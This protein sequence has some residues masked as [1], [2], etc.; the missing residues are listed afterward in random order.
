MA[1]KVYGDANNEHIGVADE[2]D[3]SITSEKRL[4]QLFDSG[5]KFEACAAQA[6]VIEGLA[7]HYLIIVKAFAGATVSP[8]VEAGLKN[9]RLTFG[10]VKDAIL[11]ANALTDA[12]LATDLDQYA[13]ERNLIAHHLVASLHDFDLD[14]FYLRGQRVMQELWRECR[15]LVMPKIQPLLDA[16]R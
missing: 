4:K 1:F 9:S 7:L 15:R 14:G 6:A 10:Q 12:T 16:E 2:Q 11:S 13:R 8:S 3:R 5:F